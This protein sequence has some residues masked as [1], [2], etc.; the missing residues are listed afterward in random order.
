[1]FKTTLPQ[2][3]SPSTA[4][5]RDPIGLEPR[6]THADEA[7]PKERDAELKWQ[8]QLAHEVL[9]EQAGTLRELAKH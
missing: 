2:P 7:V 1:M 4:D 6:L 8:V 5:V 3:A 9:V